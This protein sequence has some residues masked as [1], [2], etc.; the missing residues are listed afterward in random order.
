MTP[1]LTVI[2]PTRNRAASVLRLLHALS[3]QDPVDGGFEV[4]IVADG[5][6]DATAQ[7]VRSQPWNFDVRVIEI[8]ASGPATARSRGAAA[9]R[10]DILLFLDDDVEPEPAALRAHAAF[11]ATNDDAIA[12][13]YLPPVAIGSG[14]LANALRGWWESMFD[15]PRRPGHR[16]SFRDLLSG[17]VSIRRAHFDALGGF[18]PS[19]QCHEDWELGYRAL[20]AGLHLRFEPAAIARHHDE[21]DLAKSFRRKFA[22]G[23]ADVQLAR[24]HPELIPSLPIGWFG[25]A[26]ARRSR[27]ARLAWRYP[28]VGDRVVRALARLL[29]VLEAWRLRF[30]WRALLERLMTY[31]YWRGV[32]ESSGSLDALARLLASAPERRE[33][34]MVVNLADGLDTVFAQVEARRPRS[35]RILHRGELVGD[36]E[37]RAGWEPLRASHVRREL[38]RGFGRRVAAAFARAGIIPA[39]IGVPLLKSPPEHSVAARTKALV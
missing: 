4:V 33:P 20:Q 10:G 8:P 31:W 36:I 22:E 34:E 5:T 19:L 32:A 38:A 25:T 11:H 15:G 17:H 27:L 39:V 9:G 2:T 35:L 1:A 16:Y 3:R 37:E 29:P 30:R 23:V 21:T 13:G 28:R 14:L 7:R 18:D 24:M 26:S 6:T 12:V